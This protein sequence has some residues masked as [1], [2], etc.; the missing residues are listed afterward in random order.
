MDIVFSDIK[1][2][3]GWLVLEPGGLTYPHLKTPPLLFGQ[4]PPR[5]P[6]RT[7]PLP[8]ERLWEEEKEEEKEGESRRR[9][10]AGLSDVR[11]GSAVLPGRG[12]EAAAEAGAGA[13]RAGR[14]AALGGRQD[15]RQG[16]RR[17]GAA[18]PGRRRRPEEGHLRHPRC[19]CS[20]YPASRLLPPPARVPHRRGSGDV[21]LVLRS[22][23]RP[24]RAGP[25][26]LQSPA[27]WVWVS[28]ILLPLSRTHSSPSGSA[29]ISQVQHLPD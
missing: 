2:L 6:P 4:H 17:A 9:D 16:P 15:G 5:V 7:R 21:P 27:G 19:E 8:A 28:S 26:V 18:R 29:G 11:A 3:E 24:A 13:A 25:R 20:L 23:H 12:A 22:L 14:A 1:C 10:E